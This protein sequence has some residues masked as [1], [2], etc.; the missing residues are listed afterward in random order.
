LPNRPVAGKILPLH[1][2]IVGAPDTGKATL[3]QALVNEI[4]TYSEHLKVTVVDCTPLIDD[5]FSVDL[6]L[7]IGLDSR[8]VSIRQTIH[9]QL[10]SALAVS[11][12][13]FAVIYG[14]PQTRKQS[15]LDAIAHHL[16]RPIARSPHDT[17]W[18]W[19]CETCADAQC[20]QKLFTQLL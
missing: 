3:A 20:E 11:N 14:D 7:F 4:S 2:A 17:V 13:P 1:I 6:A 5:I 15:A 18:K 16:T 19:A 8:D 12:L 10:R 9:H